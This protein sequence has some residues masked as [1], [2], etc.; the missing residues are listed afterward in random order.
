M[1]K[2]DGS[3]GAE[4]LKLQNLALSPRLTDLLLTD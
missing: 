4:H 1:E 3:A 2:L